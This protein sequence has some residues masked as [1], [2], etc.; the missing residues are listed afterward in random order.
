M[1]E[2]IYRARKNKRKK[3]NQKVADDHHSNTPSINSPF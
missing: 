1:P 3:P 2:S